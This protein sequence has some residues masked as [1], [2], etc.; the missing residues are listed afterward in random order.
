MKRLFDAAAQVLQRPEVKAAL[1]R[2]GTD[3]ALSKSPE[4]F[5]AFLIDDNRFWAKLV[6]DAGVKLE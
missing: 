5:A 2:E 1:A 6:K 3:V 4:D